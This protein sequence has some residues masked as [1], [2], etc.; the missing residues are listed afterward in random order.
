MRRIVLQGCRRSA[1]PGRERSAR[2]ASCDHSRFARNAIGAALGRYPSA[3]TAARLAL[4][5]PASAPCWDIFC[6]V[7]DNY[8]DVGVAW[9]LA[10]QLA[11]EH[12][13]PVR[14]FVTDL[15][16][17]ARLAPEIDPARSAQVARGVAVHRWVG[18]HA[19]LTE[20]PGAVVV[21]AFG[22]GLPKAYLAAMVA[23]D[24]Q[25]LWINLEYLS[26]E[27]WIESCHG[28]ASRHPT[29]PL[30]RY[31][32]FPG[33]SATSGGLLRERDLFARRDRFRAD[34]GARD[35]L[36][37]MLGRK[38]PATG[39]L[40]VSLFCY[41]TAALPSLLDAWVQ[42]NR[43]LLCLVPEGVAQ[44]MLERWIG[45]AAPA[46][47]ELVR[48]RLALAVVPFLAQDDYDRLL[49]ACDLNLVR[50]EDSFLRAQWA[51]RPLVWHVYPQTLDAHRLKLKAFVA[52]Y[53]TA[54]EAGAAEAW[55]N[56]LR[57][58]NGEGDV[59]VAWPAFVSAQAELRAH[60]ERWAGECAGQA[61]LAAALVKFCADRV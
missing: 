19:D 34:P 18:P 54:L 33:F 15:A 47:A 32:Y 48:G 46:G 13:L 1:G 31:F 17:L 2:H 58:W 10:R 4:T 49:W 37:R 42:G 21:E 26:A 14:L 27:T 60:A 45:G 22:C 30:T 56:F 40:V 7:V 53:G 51:A 16:V 20:V 24:R 35:T 8:G 3:A 9:R 29:L 44:A 6:A 23:P 50:G 12:N 38:A 5:M 61:D 36:W 55:G 28:L 59:A 25:P 57:A 39:T 11:G 52:R 41:A 43:P